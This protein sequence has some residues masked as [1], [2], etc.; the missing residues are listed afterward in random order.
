MFNISTHAQVRTHTHTYMHA[1]TYINTHTHAYTDTIHSHTHTHTHAHTH[2]QRITYSISTYLWLPVFMICT[3]SAMQ[4]KLLLYVHNR[5]MSNFHYPTKNQLLF[6]KSATYLT[7]PLA[8]AR[9]SEL[10]PEAKIIIILHD[11]VIRAYSWY[12]VSFVWN[13]FQPI[14]N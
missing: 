7:H 5:Y 8:P 1:Y 9:A 13:S 3:L 14:S 4:F 6:E 10:L 2:T 11:P 12:Q